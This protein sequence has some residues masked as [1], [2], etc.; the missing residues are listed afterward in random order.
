MRTRRSELALNHEAKA[1]MED[2]SLF[3][4]IIY[5]FKSAPTV[6]DRNKASFYIQL[7][8][9]MENMR[10]FLSV[11][12]ACVVTGRGTI[13]KR[14]EI[15]PHS[16]PQRPRSFWSAPRIATSGQVQRHSGFDNRLR[17]EPIR[18]LRLDSEYAQSDGKSVNRGFPLLDLARGRDSWC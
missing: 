14:V 3:P 2:Y 1:Y 12:N 13:P 8:E 10:R 16:R 9:I 11:W 17:P 4:F 15:S 6:I 7:N 5:C 18:F